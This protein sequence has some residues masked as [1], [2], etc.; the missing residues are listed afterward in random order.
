MEAR[1]ERVVAGLYRQTHD[2]ERAVRRYEYFRGADPSTYYCLLSF[3][4]YHGFLAHQS[5]GH[6]EAAV[7]ELSELTEEMKLEWV[8]P[9]PQASPL[10]PTDPQPLP[11]DA[12]AVAA[13][14][15]ERFDPI[16]AA[17]WGGV[18]GISEV[19]S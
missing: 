10:P 17:W 3:D 12:S 16:G 6:H 18:R 14:Y 1:F 2:T 5:S 19:T 7:P 8:D 9:L 4:D 11:P 15:H 13:R